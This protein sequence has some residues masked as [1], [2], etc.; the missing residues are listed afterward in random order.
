MSGRIEVGFN[1]NAAKKYNARA[2]RRFD[3]PR[4]IPEKAREA[5]PPLNI[6]PRSASNDDARRFAEAVVALQTDLGFNAWD[7]DGMYG[8]ATHEAAAKRFAPVEVFTRYFM[9]NGRRIETNPSG[10]VSRLVGLDDADALDLHRR[11]SHEWNDERA[12]KF[13]VVHWGG[14]DP[15]HLARYFGGTPKAVSSHFGVGPRGTYQFLDTGCVSYHG[16]GV[17]DGGRRLSMNLHSIGIDAAQFPQPSRAVWY[18]KHD[19][20]PFDDIRVVENPE[21]AAAGGRGLAKLLSLDSRTAKGVGELVEDLCAAF[22]LALRAPR[23]A[24]GSVR[25]TTL[26][27]DEL[28]AIVEGR[29]GAPTVIGHHHISKTKPD[30]IGWWRAAFEGTPLA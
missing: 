28:E 13:I 27:F 8:P 1:L 10:R 16:G 9:H 23:N 15:H 11:A 2:A 29:E 21:R 3:I 25:H 6:D 30:V 26:S 12:V 5:F 18:E 17:R 14:R 22:G 4:G 20:D 7:I 19:D 24:D